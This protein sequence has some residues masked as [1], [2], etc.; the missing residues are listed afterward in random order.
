MRAEEAAL[1]R[2]AREQRHVFSRDQAYEFGLDRKAV[3]HRMTSGQW[4]EVG[5]R[6]FTF[7]GIELD[8]KGRLQAGLLD[9]GPTAMVTAQAAAA[10]YSL[11]SFHPGPLVFI[12]PRELRDRATV[13]EVISCGSLAGRDRRVVDGLPTTSATMT[14]VQLAGRVELE[15]LGDA[16]DSACRK[17]LT[18]E[19]DVWKRLGATSGR[20]RKGIDDLRRLFE[21]AGVESWLERRFLE[22]LPPGVP[23]PALQG[24]YRA[25]GQHVARV[26]FD[27]DPLPVIVEVGG[28]KG[29][30]SAAERRDKE[31][32]RN[33][34]QLRG[35]VVYFF[36]REDVV[37]T[38]DAVV[39][40]LTAALRLAS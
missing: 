19:A 35:K 25:D 17:R 12:V 9:L 22:L 34:L 8:W 13:G 28:R 15:L 36:C 32:R 3:Y 37:E 5:P 1:A 33:R 38:P 14:L 2:I 23:R 11:D 16:L 10:S 39:R 20:G 18:T 29:Y 27:F 24:I 4:I 21:H 31:Q 26:D 6:T 7:A 40:I 30:M